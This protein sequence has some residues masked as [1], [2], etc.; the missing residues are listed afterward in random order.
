MDQRSRA[1]QGHPAFIN[2]RGSDARAFYQGKLD[3]SLG[4]LIQNRVAYIVWGKDDAN[5]ATDKNTRQRI[6]SRIHMQYHWVTI[7]KY[8]QQEYGLWVLKDPR[9]QNKS[10]GY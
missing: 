9:M 6:H 3:N 10:V 7:Q 5:R 1:C 4:W 8:G 2:Q